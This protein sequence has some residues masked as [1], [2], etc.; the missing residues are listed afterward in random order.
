VSSPPPRASGCGE[1][2]CITCADDG[3]A[4]TVVRVDAER[5]LALCVDAAGAYSTV[6]IALVDQ[7]LPGEALLVHAG[8]AIASLG[9]PRA[10]AAAPPRAKVWVSA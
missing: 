8:T 5:A 2:H 10:G 7:P 1:E 4:M 3:V 9:R 6:E